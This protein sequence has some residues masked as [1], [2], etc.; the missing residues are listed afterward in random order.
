MK[1]W[2]LIACLA[3]LLAAALNQE[4][5]VVQY[6]ITSPK[7]NQ[8]TTLAVLSD[9]HNTFYGED[10]AQLIA[11]IRAAQPD[12]L[13]MTGDM[14]D[15]YAELQGVLCLLEG[16]DGE[17]PVYYVSGNHECAGDDLEQILAGL[18][19]RG[20]QVLRGESAL[21]RGG[22]RIA[23]VDDPLCLTPEEWQEQ[24][25]ACRNRDDVFTLLMSHRPDRVD[26]YRSG[27]D[28]V[29]AGHAHGGQVRIP[30]IIDGL[31][32]PNQG[33]L[34]KY[35]GG[36]YDLGEGSMAVSRGLSRGVI[37]RIFNRPELM[38]LHLKASE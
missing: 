2:I 11:R 9:L 21:L 10:Q 25:E 16:L 18:R 33:F 27:F 5:A 32:A 35:T 4:L 17:Y 12:A 38:I 8:D 37:P 28:L 24:I 36:L 20:V 31:W 15:S 7:L 14:A 22:V 1:K 30:G 19:E 34:P 3:L 29:V 13:L 6:E 26:A 23:G